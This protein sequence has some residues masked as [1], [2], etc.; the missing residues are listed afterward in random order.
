MFANVEFDADPEVLLRQMQVDLPED[1]HSM[2]AERKKVDPLTAHLVDDSKKETPVNK[3][4]MQT[5][6]V[7]VLDVRAVMSDESIASRIKKGNLE[8]IRV[9]ADRWPFYLESQY[10]RASSGLVNML[11]QLQDEAESQAIRFISA[12]KKFKSLDKRVEFVLEEAQNR[13]EEEDF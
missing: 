3:V 10:D 6:S 8:D 13:D 1:I 7:G 5:S 9:R 12:T 4:L 11:A 2:P